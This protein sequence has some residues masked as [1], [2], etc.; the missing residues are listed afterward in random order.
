VEKLF[1][2]DYDDTLA[3]NT[4][5]YV[6]AKLK[7]ALFVT[8][9]LGPHA[10]N[11]VSILEL[12]E[13]IDV[14]NVARFGF[15][16]NR[17]PTSMREAYA[18]ICKA[19][20]IPPARKDLDR[21]YNIGMS[22][23]N[24]SE[25]KRH[26]LLPGAAATLDFLAE[27]HDELMLYTKGDPK[28]QWEKIKA[29]HIQRWFGGSI[30][31]V[32]DKDANGILRLI[33]RRDPARVW[34]VGNGLRSDVYPALEAGIGAIYIPWETWA[35]ERQ[36]NGEPHDNPRYIKFPKIDDIIKNYSTLP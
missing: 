36:H 5:Y 14:E 1:I 2:F 28:V 6:R 20:G 21:A 7:F 17:F 13:R 19:A 10:P 33:G 16:R 11:E 18:L 24:K 34:K 30:N 9:R 27:Q 3:R 31:V 35:F 23:F 32:G 15:K 12:Q 25:Y 8:E 22:A 4:L 26:G 29:T